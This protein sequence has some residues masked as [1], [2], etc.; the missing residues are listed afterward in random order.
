MSSKK[1]MKQ[2]QKLSFQKH[3]NNIKNNKFKPK[4]N[5]VFNKY[6]K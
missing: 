3:K 4:T 6:K 2:M 1:A 5:K